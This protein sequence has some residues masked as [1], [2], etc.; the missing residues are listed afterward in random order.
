MYTKKTELAIN[1][2]DKLAEHYDRHTRRIDGIR[3]ST[4]SRLNLK[5]GDVVMDVACGTGVSFNQLIELIGPEGKLIGIE[6]SP[7]MISQAKKRVS[8]NQWKNVELISTPMEAAEITDKVDAVLLNY[9]QD[10]M[11]SKLAMKKIFQ[12]AQNGTRFAISGLKFFPWW[13]APFNLYL[14]FRSR[15][16]VTTFEGLSAPWSL[17]QSYIPNLCVSSTLLGRGYIADG[18]YHD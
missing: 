15:N 12:S 11:R 1:H 10:V 2:Y 9:A 4:I 16:Y 8:L 18:V 6:Q 17:V 13:L 14:M 3:Q 5:P 7:G